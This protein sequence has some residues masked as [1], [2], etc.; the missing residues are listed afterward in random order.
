MKTI[1]VGAAFLGC[2]AA[3][4]HA[5]TQYDRKL[6]QAVMDIVAAKMGG[7]RGGFSFDS[8]P[9]FVAATVTPQPDPQAMRGAY[10]ATDPWRDGL[11][12]AIERQPTKGLF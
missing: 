11:A 4:A 10:S 7:L 2:M 5:D 9:A 12:P 6:E 8:K 1:W 3:S